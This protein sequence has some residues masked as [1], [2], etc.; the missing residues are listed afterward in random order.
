MSI[1]AVY[2]EE[3][4]PG[5]D[6]PILR[7]AAECLELHPYESWKVFEERVV[8]MADVDP[9]AQ[10]LARLMVSG[11]I[12]CP[13]DKQGRILVPPHLRAYAELDKDVTVAGVGRKLELWNTSRF[14]AKLIQSQARLEDIKSSLA[15]KLRN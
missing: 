3:L 13:I 11:A 9:E 8:D 1:P 14:D 4:Q 6:A 10:G 12:E 5:A 7:N 2:R 15:A